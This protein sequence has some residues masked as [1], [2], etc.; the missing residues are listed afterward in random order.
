M[1][2]GVSVSDPTKTEITNLSK[3]ILMCFSLENAKQPITN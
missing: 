2:M 3:L 1:N